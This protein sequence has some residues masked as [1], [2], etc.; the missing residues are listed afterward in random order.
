MQY[1]STG[2][3]LHARRIHLWIALTLVLPLWVMSVT[4]ALMSWRSVLAVQ[5]PAAWL[6]SGAAMRQAAVNAVWA[7]RDGTVWIG[8]GQGLAHVTNGESQA[9]GEF[10]GLEVLALVADPRHDTPLILT[11]DGVWA[12]G[13]SGWTLTYKGRVRQLS[14]QVDGSALV[15]TMARGDTSGQQTYVSHDGVHW[16]SDSTLLAALDRSPID[17]APT[18]PLNQL[19]KEIHSGAYLLGRGPGEMAWG[20]LLSSGLALVMSAGLWVWGR[21]TLMRRP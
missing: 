13:V 6:G 21:R 17:D 10:R 3:A 8:R 12:R 5:V 15:L 18:V 9:I 2:R 7:G 16:A 20:S 11:R 14:S 1:R 19:V 4:G